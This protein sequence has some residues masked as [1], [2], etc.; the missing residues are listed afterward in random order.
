MCIRDRSVTPNTYSS[1][2]TLPSPYVPNSKSDWILS[3][4]LE[5]T[6]TILPVLLFAIISTKLEIGTNPLEVLTLKFSIISKVLPSEG[7]L[8]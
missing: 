7:Y 3:A 8:K 4:F 5:S 1:S 2:L 6:L